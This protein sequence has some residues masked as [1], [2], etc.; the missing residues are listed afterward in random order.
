MNQVMFCWNS[1]IDKS[2]DLFRI[3][4]PYDINCNM[5]QEY[6]NI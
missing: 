1:V 4:C 6:L 2:R 3:E 5:K